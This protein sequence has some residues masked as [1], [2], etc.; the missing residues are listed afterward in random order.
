MTGNLVFLLLVG[1]IIVLLAF[2]VLWSVLMLVGAIYRKRAFDREGVVTEGEVVERYIRHHYKGAQQY[3]VVYRFTAV[4]P[5]GQKLPVD[6]KA[7]VW[8]WDYDKLVEGTKV[9][10]EYLPGSPQT[11]RLR[12]K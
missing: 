1:A 7:N 11:S 12:R 5:D 2:V 9:S 10:V 6:G 4:L 3:W 8:L